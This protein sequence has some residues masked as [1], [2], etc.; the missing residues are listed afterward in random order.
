MVGK[1]STNIIESFL[2]NNSIHI[3]ID[4]HIPKI[5]ILDNES[6][7]PEDIV[8]RIIS[9]AYGSKNVVVQEIS[10]H[11]AKKYSFFLGRVQKEQL[12]KF[13]DY[14]FANDF[15]ILLELIKQDKPADLDVRNVIAKFDTNQN[16]VRKSVDVFLKNL[17]NAINSNN[18]KRITDYVSFLFSRLVALNENSKISLKY[19]FDDN[20]IIL[21]SE[22]SDK[23]YKS[24][25]EFCNKTQYDERNIIICEFNEKYLKLLHNSDSSVEKPGLIYFKIDQDLFD[26]FSSEHD[27]F[28]YVLNIINKSYDLLENHRTLAIKIDNVF[29]N[30]IN[31]KWKLYAYLTIYA[32]KFKEV[33]ETKPYY[34][35]LDILEDTFKHK[36]DLEFSNNERTK[37]ERYFR[38]LISDEQLSKEISNNKFIEEIKGYKKYNHGFSFIDCYVLKTEENI[39]SSEINFIKN[40]NELL[41]IFA[42]HE[43]D[44]RK[45]PCPICGSLKISG[46]SFPELGIK[47][48]ECKNPLCSARSKTNRGKRYSERTILMQ[49]ATFDFSNE[50]LIPKELIKI[51]RKDVVENWNKSNLYDM[52]IK[53]FT[54]VSDRIFIVE[55]HESLDFLE[56]AKQLKRGYK[57]ISF[58]DF[59]SLDL[60]EKNIFDSFF[61]KSDFIKRFIYERNDIPSTDSISK[62]FNEIKGFEIL[63][64][65]CL[66]VLNN[67]T[68][69]TVHHMVTSP[70]YYNAREYSQW[71]NLYN[72]LNDMYNINRK[73]F[74]ALKSGGIFFYNI[75][76]IFDNEKTVVKS[77][78]GEKRIP[79][80][81]Y[82]IFLFIEAGFELLDNVIW[83]KGE[84]QSNRHKNDGNYSPYY[85]RPANCYEHM[86]I[87]KKPGDLLTN[88]DMSE[89]IL[90]EN[91]IKFTPVFKI[92]KGGENR[93]GHTA[94][95][96]KIL[97]QLSISCFT[98]KNHYV[99]DPFSGSGTSAIVARNM[100]RHGI[101]I[102]LKPEY[103]ELSLIKANEDLIKS[104]ISLEKWM[105]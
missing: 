95:Y 94:P 102:E 8:E 11:L 56:K 103:I 69:E 68:A 64:G 77:K 75:G 70:P 85:Q 38:G 27:F 80:G 19:L 59:V 49:D 37:I 36:Y 41:L 87:F 71:Q 96:P 99:L 46:N 76:D 7:L 98:S 67:L 66:H 48:W 30:K 60:Y 18:T 86:F 15:N 17:N 32:E 100:E 40:V 79:L 88:S 65:N 12:K 81:A 82:T 83:Y 4:K 73:S 53:Y 34:N 10:N 5:K 13:L 74:F 97:P 39:N 57:S 54:Y 55:E 91:I 31:I 93:F 104:N 22:L 42:K 63:E 72:Y 101:G 45:I 90:T 44:D 14:N 25:E 105:H 52:L 3:N 2:K 35:A 47:S 16:L 43:I 1:S 21:K 89:N 61:K 26:R 58:K 24:F 92:G 23:E 33:L 28:D 51:W 20:K 78:M 9:D 84:T 29:S 62:K 50:N 6:S